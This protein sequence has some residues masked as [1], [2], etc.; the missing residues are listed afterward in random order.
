M[1]LWYLINICRIKILI[2]ISITNILVCKYPNHCVVNPAGWRFWSWSLVRTLYYICTLISVTVMLQDGDCNIDLYNENCNLRNCVLASQTF[3]QIIV[4]FFLVDKDFDPGRHI[5]NLTWQIL[6]YHW[7]CSCGRNSSIQ[8]SIMQVMLDRSD[9]H[10]LM[11]ISATS[12]SQATVRDLQPV[13]NNRMKL[14]Q[15]K[16]NTQIG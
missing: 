10:L 5:S 7:I 1:H 12:F 3:I 13:D 15:T 4:T 14:I 2:R 8:I 11:G 16:V 6:S 9:W